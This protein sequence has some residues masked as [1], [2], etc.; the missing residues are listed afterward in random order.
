MTRCTAKTLLGRRCKNSGNH[1]G[2]CMI[3]VGSVIR[4]VL[5]PRCGHPCD[6]DTPKCCEC[7]DRRPYTE[8]YTV[9]MDGIGDIE[10]GL[11]SDG[12]CPKCKYDDKGD[13]TLYKSTRDSLVRTMS[14]MSRDQ[15]REIIKETFK[16]K[17]IN[18]TILNN[19]SS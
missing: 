11:R 19:T 17:R 10:T 8:T 16:E 5:L 18:G 6:L 12:Y 9:Y 13:E 7:S 3:H 15:I 14:L 1:N 4:S 2:K